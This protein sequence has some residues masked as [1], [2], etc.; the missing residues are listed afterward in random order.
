MKGG[1][2][3]VVSSLI[4]SNDSLYDKLRTTDVI[5]L[6]YTLRAGTFFGEWVVTMRVDGGVAAYC[7]ARPQMSP[8]AALD[9]LIAEATHLETYLSRFRK[10]KPRIVGTYFA[11]NSKK[12]EFGD[13]V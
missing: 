9:L 5:E 8:S 2:A 4:G 11:G 1:L 7:H 13:L 12:L 3:S 6:D 10:T